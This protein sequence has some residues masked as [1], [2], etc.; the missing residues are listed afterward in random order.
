MKTLKQLFVVIVAA[1]ATTFYGEEAKV[2]TQTE[3]AVTVDL[4][5]GG[6]SSYIDKDAV[7]FYD[8]LVTQGDVT[9]SAENGLY[10]NIWQSHGLRGH[11]LDQVLD[12]T[13]YHLGWAGEIGGL[14]IDVSGGYYDLSPIMKDTRNGIKSFTI[15]LRPAGDRPLTPFVSIESY[16]TKSDADFEGGTRTRVGLEFSLSVGK[17]SIEQ[18]LEV[19]HED[20]A[21]GYGKATVGIYSADVVWNVGKMKL[22]LP[23]FALYH[24]FTEHDGQKT[25]AVVGIAGSWSF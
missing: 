3:K 1:Y 11:R 13:D 24:P 25:K 17:A 6:Y 8:G 12:E 20:G 5:L 19:C 7:V 9:I 21:F 14:A 4:R 18:S 10:L 2:E 22:I 16:H 23:S 15:E